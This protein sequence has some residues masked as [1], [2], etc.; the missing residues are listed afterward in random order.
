[1]SERNG[2]PETF[3]END[4]NVLFPKSEV[5]DTVQLANS[6]RACAVAYL[7]AGDILFAQIKINSTLVL[8]CT[9]NAAFSCELFLKSIV[10]SNMAQYKP[11]KGHNL[12]DLL[13]ML[14]CDTK[15]AILDI[16]NKHDTN[17]YFKAFFDENKNAFVDLRYFYEKG[18][19]EFFNPEGLLTLAR[20][21]NDYID[22][23]HK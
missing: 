18:R 6:S 16:I 13:L 4:I 14:P 20:V 19:S 10:Y 9:I 23:T 15:N 17:N 1:M 5:T 8:P 7:N 11:I 22:N 3:N 21:L 2:L 12:E